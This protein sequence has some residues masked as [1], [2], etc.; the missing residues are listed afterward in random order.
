[1]LFLKIKDLV[2]NL[3]HVKWFSGPKTFSGVLRKACLCLFVFVLLNSFS[4]LVFGLVTCFTKKKFLQ[5]LEFLEVL[6]GSK[7]VAFGKT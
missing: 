1:M 5:L 4:V 7:M 6:G 2:M 3:M